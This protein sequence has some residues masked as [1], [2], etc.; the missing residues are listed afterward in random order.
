MNVSKIYQS[1]KGH[2]ATLRKKSFNLC[3]GRQV[4]GCG[5]QTANCVGDNP[6]EEEETV[7][8][9]RPDGQGGC[10]V[11]GTALN[12]QYIP[13][14]SRTCFACFEGFIMLNV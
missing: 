11:Q 1:S 12:K 3:K 6:E 10:Q 2:V 14:V 9:Q 7:Q 5:R 13:A 8:E 4:N